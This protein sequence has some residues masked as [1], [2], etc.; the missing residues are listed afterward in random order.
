V[1]IAYTSY[2]VRAFELKWSSKSSLHRLAYFYTKI[3]CTMHINALLWFLSEIGLEFAE[4]SQ[5][6]T[7]D[8]VESLTGQQQLIIREAMKGELIKISILKT[9][10]RCQ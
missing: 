1:E 10:K 5:R 7:F 9:V 8:G 3:T 2:R 4:I 6:K